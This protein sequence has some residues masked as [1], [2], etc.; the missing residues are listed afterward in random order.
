MAQEGQPV[1]PAYRRGRVSR[2]FGR[3]II[4][5]RLQFK[6]SGIVFL[7]LAIAAFTI[8]VQGNYIIKHMIQTGV[9]TSEE[10]ISYLTMLNQN[11][12]YSSILAVAIVFGLALFFSHFVAGPLYRFEKIFEQMRD[13]DLT[14]I[15][16][17]RK[18]DELKDTAEI[19]NQALSSLRNKVRAERDALSD[20]LQKIKAVA[21]DERQAGRTE[22]ADSLDQI[23]SAIQ[24]NPPQLKI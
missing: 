9:V 20:S 2:F 21:A 24:N 12:F 17:L 8:W 1:Q 4:K 14:G 6:F 22:A 11:I 3:Y 5:N 18:H 15:A 23:V 19:L 16:R 7:F 13:G 10:A